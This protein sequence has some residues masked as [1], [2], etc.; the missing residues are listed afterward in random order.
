M[1]RQV[2]R[3]TGSDT[4]IQFPLVC[5]HPCMGRLTEQCEVGLKCCL[6]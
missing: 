6:N 2:L 1:G 4:G 3:E 5:A